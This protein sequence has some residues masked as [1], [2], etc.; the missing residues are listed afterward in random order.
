MKMNNLSQTNED[1][2]PTI[3]RTCAHGG[4][5]CKKP[6]S[7]SSIWNMASWSLQIILTMPTHLLLAAS[8]K[9]CL[10][11]DAAI[12][13]KK[14]LPENKIV[15]SCH[16]S[17]DGRPLIFTCLRQVVHFV[18]YQFQCYSLFGMYIVG[19]YLSIVCFKCIFS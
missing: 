9:S 10:S 8:G 15:G 1:Q 19:Y 13:F 7:C 16:P 18:Q 14:M 6:W 17:Y 5:Y 2:W 12:V 4:I 11:S 3:I